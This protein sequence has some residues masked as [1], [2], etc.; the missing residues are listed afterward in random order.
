MKK[1]LKPYKNLKAFW[2]YSR[3]YNKFV[4]V[5]EGF[6]SDGATGAIDV[7]GNHPV[8][9]EGKTIFVSRSW[10]VHDHLC[11]T[12]CWSDGEKLSNW[13]CSMVLKDILKKEGRWFRDFWWMIATFTLGGGEARK[14]GMF[15]VKE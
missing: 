6:L 4:F 11:E 7:R 8:E 14:N 9:Y 10:I 2:Y 15:H 3:R 12:G 1:T 13:Q 5:D